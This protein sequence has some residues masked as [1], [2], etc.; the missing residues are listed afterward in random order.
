VVQQIARSAEPAEEGSD[1]ESVDGRDT[2]RAAV[3]ADIGVVS[4]VEAADVAEMH[5][6]EASDDS[7]DAEDE[8]NDEAYEV[9]GV[10]GHCVLRFVRLFVVTG[11]G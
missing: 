3:S 1:G 4:Q 2:V 8:T 7:Q 10:H 9:E 11:C 5:V 6:A